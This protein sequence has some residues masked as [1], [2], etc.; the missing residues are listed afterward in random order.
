MNFRR[1]CYFPDERQLKFFQMYTKSN[2]EFEC[3]TNLTLRYCNCSTFYMPSWVIFSKIL[4]RWVINNRIPGTK[5]TKICTYD[6]HWKCLK[7]AEQSFSTLSQIRL[8]CDPKSID[9]VA[10]NCLPLCNDIIY[11]SE[12]DQNEHSANEIENLGFGTAG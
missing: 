4:N 11:D 9:R 8:I 1:Q 3:L 12:V 2:C 7:Y 10:C 5:E 6:Q